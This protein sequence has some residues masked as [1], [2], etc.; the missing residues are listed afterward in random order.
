ME[1]HKPL[2]KQFKNAREQ[3]GLSLDQISKS[4]KIKKDYL[5]AIEEERFDYLPTGEVYRKGFIKKYAAALGMDTEKILKEYEETK[6]SSEEMAQPGDEIDT[7]KVYETYKYQLPQKSQSLISAKTIIIIIAIIVSL[8]AAKQI[9]FNNSENQRQGDKEPEAY[10]S[11]QENTPPVE[12]TQKEPEQTLKNVEIKLIEKD[13]Y[14]T[15]YHVLNSENIQFKL[16]V[17]KDRCWVSV[18]VDGENFFEGTL[19]KDQI[20]TI[21]ARNKVWVRIGNPKVVSLSVNGEDL[22]I[23]GGNTR[24]FIFIRESKE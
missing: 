5:K 11:S 12:E 18:K 10:V 8:L 21:N 20:K 23:P 13:E 4:T 7:E 16:Q 15:E 14:N 9:L 19:T 6:S 17:I 1:E 3:K 22:G 24:N 2:G